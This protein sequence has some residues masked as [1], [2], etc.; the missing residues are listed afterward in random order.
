MLVKLNGRAP[1]TL[2][3]FFEMLGLLISLY[4]FFFVNQ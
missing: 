4:I 1:P 3:D 2:L